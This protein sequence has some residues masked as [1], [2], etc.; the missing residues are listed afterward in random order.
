MSSWVSDWYCSVS[1]IIG[2][3]RSGQYGMSIPKRWWWYIISN[4]RYDY[5]ILSLCDKVRVSNDFGHRVEVTLNSLGTSEGCSVST[6][7]GKEW[8]EYQI[9]NLVVEWLLSDLPENTH[10][11]C[12]HHTTALE[13]N[14]LI[15]KRL[16]IS[17]ANI[18]QTPVHIDGI[19]ETDTEL[20]MMRIEGVCYS[21]A[22]IWESDDCKKP[23]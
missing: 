22:R 5:K 17:E 9:E 21:N 8:N 16:A 11:I 1:K 12:A 3:K 4:G 10:T 18:L 13:W 6:Q 15:L 2:Y 14:E 23:S 19:A 20:D 7:S